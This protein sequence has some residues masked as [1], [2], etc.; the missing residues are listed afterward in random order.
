MIKTN[1]KNESFDL[2]K[3]PL[4]NENLKRSCS[5]LKRLRGESYIDSK[6]IVRPAR[7]MKA[8]PCRNQAKHSACDT[9]SDRE[10]EL[11]YREFRN[12]RSSQAQWQ[13][14]A[15][16]VYVRAKS[17]R[18]STGPSRREN[19][20]Q[21][22]LTVSGDEVKVCRRFFL[23]TLN[24][25]EAMIRTALEKLSPQGICQDDNRGRK[26]PPNKLTPDDEE[27]LRRHILS[28]RPVDSSLYGKKS[29]KKYLDSNL[30]FSLM[31][32]MYVNLCKETN[33]KYVSVETYRRICKEYNVAF[34]KPSK[35]PPKKC[36]SSAPGNCEKEC[37]DLPAYKENDGF[38]PPT[39]NN[40]FA[41]KT[42]QTDVLDFDLHSLLYMTE[43]S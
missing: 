3:P 28:F 4:K 40:G 10:R 41:S 13:F 11:I 26:P 12:L 42:G 15:S 23:A 17:K 21:Y 43:G 14:I 20:H 32:K 30:S 2:K 36:L 16:H 37:K 1:E 31:H 22:Y 24:V 7:P 9:V 29:I 38:V 18:T 5:K 25:S 27:F 6:G 8:A 34:I 33:R 19:T 39:Q 35:D